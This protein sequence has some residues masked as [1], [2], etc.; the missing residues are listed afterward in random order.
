MTEKQT[1]TLGKTSLSKLNGVH[2]NLVKVIK[3]AI[4]LT[5]QDFS[6]NEGLR[7]LERQKRL[8]AAGASRTL[9]SKHLK[10]ADGYGHASDLI[11]WGDFDGNGTKEISWAWENFY[12]IAEAMRAAAKELNIRVRWGGC[13]ETLNDTTKPTTQLV[14]DYVAERRAAGKRAFIDG[15][16][17]ELA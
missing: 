5:S 17:F 10:Q 13:W 2:P 12:P 4:E 6:V 3:R 11:P 16:H 1:Y 8:V 14:A 7:T 9:N 15:P